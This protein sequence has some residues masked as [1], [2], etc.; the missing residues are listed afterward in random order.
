MEVVTPEENKSVQSLGMEFV[1]DV[2]G[3]RVDDPVLEPLD[4]GAQ[5]RHVP[6]GKGARDH[7]G[8]GEGGRL[9]R[10]QGARGFGG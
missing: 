7:V 5:V 4:L 3:E 9:G 8:E 2:N 6:S 10:R 1:P